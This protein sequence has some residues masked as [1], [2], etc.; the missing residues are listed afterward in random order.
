MHSAAYLHALHTL[1]RKVAEVIELPPVRILPMWLVQRNLLQ[2]MRCHVGGTILAVG[3][4]ITRGW[5]I[6]VGG[7]MHHAHANDGMV[8]LT[9]LIAVMKAS[10]GHVTGVIALHAQTSDEQS[11]DENR[12][13]RPPPAKR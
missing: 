2:K 11:S 13:G 9:S 1:S 4:A 8:L 5:S 12:V 6:N 3:L 10:A 7:G